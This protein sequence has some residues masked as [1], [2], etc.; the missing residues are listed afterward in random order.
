MGKVRGPGGPDPT[1]RD[2]S[3]V[4]MKAGSLAACGPLER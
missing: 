4:T 1:G 3:G 2:R